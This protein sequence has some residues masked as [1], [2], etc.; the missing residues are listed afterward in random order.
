MKFLII[1]DEPD[2]R[3]IAIK[4]LSR[5]YPD[6][7]F[8][9]VVTEK[10]FHECLEKENYDVVIT[11]YHLHWSN[12]IRILMEI[13]KRSPFTPVIMLTG[14]GTE[15]VAVEAMKRGLD[16]YVL[17]T[18]RHFERLPAS[19]KA[20]IEREEINRKEKMLSSIV[21]H[22]KE[23]MVSVDENGK[24]IYANRAVEEI[25]GWGRKEIIGKHMSILAV[26]EKK[27]RK[28]FEKALKNGWAKFETVRKAKDGNEIPVLMTIIPFRDE[29][30]NLIFS[31]AIIV[32]IR[33][34]KEY[35]EKL[36]HMNDLLKAL[37]DVNQLI[38]REKDV[39]K[40]LRKTCDII[41]GVEKYLFV[42]LDMDGGEYSVGDDEICS[43][44]HEVEEE[45]K[46]RERAERGGKEIIEDFNGG[47]IAVIP[48]IKDEFAFLTIIVKDGD[49]YEEEIDL[50]KEMCND[51]SLAIHTINL[52]K[53]LYEEEVLR[54]AILSAVPIGIGF[55]INRI[56]GWANETMYRMTGY[57]PEETLGK[58]AR[59]LYESDEEYK[60]VGREIEKAL[61]EGKI[62]KVETRWKR[63]DGSVFDCLLYARYA[64]P[65]KPEEGVIVAAVDITESKK[66]KDALKESEEKYRVLA[67]NSMDGIFL[68]KGYKLVY[69][70]PAFLK[71]FALK[72]L[73]Q[74]TEK[75]LLEFLDEEDAEKIVRDVGK[76]LRG[77]KSRARYELKIKRA[78][79][80]I[81]FVDLAMNKVI[82][83]GEPHALGIVKDITEKKK[84]MDELRQSEEKYRTLV[85]HAN[86]GV[87]IIQDG[88]IKYA[89]PRLLEMGGYTLKEMLGQDFTKFVAVEEIKKL[90]ERYEKRM[91][92]EEVETTYETVLLRKDGSRVYVEL[93]VA[94]IDYEGR[95]AELVIVRDISER[96]ELLEKL[97]ESENRFK[98]IFENAAVG[99]YRTTPDGR[100]LMA[101]PFLVQL[102]GYESE[103]ELKKRDLNE[104]EYYEPGYERD[105]FI[106]EIE[107]KG[108][109][110]GETAWK[111]KDGR[112]IWVRESAVAIKDRDGK[113]LYYDGVIEDI[114]ELKKKEAQLIKARDDW[115][116]IFNFIT[117]PVIVLAKDHTIL[118]ANPATLKA[119][120]K[121]REEVIGKKCFEFFH[122]GKKIAKG[123]PME[124]LLKSKKPETETM[125]MEALGGIYIVS[126]SPIFE[127]GNIIRI[128]HHAKDITEL[129]R[130][131]REL[132]DSEARFRGIFESAID[133]IFLMKGDRFIHCNPAALQIFGC[134]EKDI[135]GA[136]PYKFSPPKQPD[137]SDSK[138]KAL[139]IIKEAMEGKPQRFEWKHSRLD[140][141]T[142]D[143]EVILNRVKLGGEYYIMTIVR[144]ITARKKAE[145]ERKRHAELMEKM[146]SS[147][148]K[149]NGMR[150][151]E[152]IY[153]YTAEV[154]KDMVGDAIVV[155][156]SMDGSPTLKIKAVKGSEKQMDNVIKILGRS[157]VGMDLPLV[158][159]RPHLS[160]RT[161]VK[162]PYDLPSLLRKKLPEKTISS[163][164]KIVGERDIYS[165]N[166]ME[167]ENLFGNIAILLR[168]GEKIEKRYIEDFVHHVSATIL[169][170]KAEK[171]L[172]ESEIRYRQLYEN[173]GVP[174]F[175]YDENLIVTDVN[176]IACIMAG[177]KKEDV[178]GKNMLDL[179]ILHPAD[180]KKTLERIEKLFSGKEDVA[181]EKLRLRK[182]DGSYGI[183]EIYATIRKFAGRREIINVCHDVT[184]RERL[185]E[186][187]AESEK[188]FRGLVENAHDAIYIVSPRGFEYV[189]PAF[190]KLTGYS[191]EELLSKDFSFWALIHPD[192]IEKIKEREKARRRRRKIPSRYEFRIIT[193][194][195]ETRV[196]EASTVDV[197]RGS[198]RV[199][200]MLRDVTER[201]K[202]QEE[203]SKLSNLHYSI[204]MGIN[205]NDTVEGLCRDLLAS[206][207]DVL[208]IDYG[209]IFI[210]SRDKKALIPVAHLGYPK[211]MM[212]RIVKEYPLEKDQ[213]W[214]AVKVFLEAKEKYLRNIQRYK[215]LAFNRDLYKKYGIKELYTIP[216]LVKGK[217]CGV[218]QVASRENNPFTDDKR[219]I[220]RAI[221]EEIAAG[222]AKIEAEEKM[223]EALEKERRFKLDTSHY[224]FNP[225]AIAKGYLQLAL[226][227]DDGKDNILKAIE[228]IDRVEKVVK[229]ITTKGEIRE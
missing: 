37:K 65:E 163:I 127:G 29:R 128:I 90:K 64:N 207:K 144:D 38:Q 93:S 85:E 140:G 73:K 79:G 101:N 165:M 39:E 10:Q 113:T 130:I 58:D 186:E 14:T 35:E 6:A 221:S 152:E 157:P 114:S 77:E 4:F 120:G 210:Y 171:A 88:K 12:G 7:E 55:T 131:I 185:I 216:L 71:I 146:A 228:A 193:K 110:I 70:N 159:E 117:D 183:F 49:F 84:L 173:A 124:K 26:D 56:L 67:E 107:K 136:T 57:S 3:K 219:K 40:L 2:D 105:K 89:N 125:E 96:K 126:V 134:E 196:V 32:D 160:G 34:Q 191:K 145:E 189:N 204:G 30:G 72:S 31:S 118:D 15:E 223:R 95:P 104:K 139:E 115:E 33:E 176:E 208:E 76:A 229:N 205:R 181:T 16:D 162:L 149:M 226:E 164:I 60:R 197:G 119:L 66:L 62:A 166:L 86:D 222:I 17:K 122:G 106:K 156:S 158:G 111:R 220:L 108:Y 28:E 82:Y 194:N 151:E 22:S 1:D 211:E 11:D 24:I 141:S 121:S 98:S 78:D 45:K 209:S 143:A 212:R 59:I 123:C 180:M 129:K 137:G 192:D 188:R 200:G 147:T 54:E 53:A 63:K 172:R 224:F 103:E 132:E 83:N 102:L 153:E 213:P 80:S 68:A 97:Q 48:V 87:G 218:L 91:S 52:S 50:L 155:V 8:V 92:G 81:A 169:K 74:A 20:A 217:V 46:L 142:F 167:G 116:A 175:T 199:I 182:A 27:Q 47:K 150:R 9:E 36:E 206:I 201:I 42:C 179:N 19:V 112:T 44:L 51:I 170:I 69:A 13:K 190:E 5:A 195:G 21:E 133:A 154:I 215:P 184:D 135:I 177:V 168:K 202:A 43:R 109:F 198:Y 148:M 18:P 75:N 25:F 214:V 61:K 178:V 23:A 138:K 225:I 100:I 203:I 161:L 187:L 99:I 41:A 227:E 174:I 94:I